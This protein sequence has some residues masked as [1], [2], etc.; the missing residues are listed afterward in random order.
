MFKIIQ[1][2]FKF[3]YFLFLIIISILFLLCEGVIH[4]HYSI[5]SYY[6]YS[7]FIYDRAGY[8]PLIW[9]ENGI[10]EF[11]QVFIL[12][13]S[14]IILFRYV[15]L[16]FKNLS[17]FFQ[18]ILSIYLIGLI[19]YF[20]E[21][22][23]YGQHFFFWLTPEFF[24]KL[25]SQNE[26]NLHNIN[27]LFNQLPRTLLLLFCSLSFLF[28]K[29][30]RFKSKNLA[31]FVLPSSKLK[32]LSCLILLFVIPDLIRDIFDIKPFFLSWEVDIYPFYV[33]VD[34]TQLLSF[35]FIRLSELQELL[36]NL[37]IISHVYYLKNFFYFW[38][39]Y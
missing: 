29:L 11:T 23:S 30:I 25:N 18:I 28:E 20:F 16:H 19:Y 15:K 4:N 33:S 37:Y 7:E 12:L 10:V 2:K 39:Y 34:L 35:T 5:F 8:N 38:D 32:Y 27:N 26:T 24:S 31:L 22:I 21:E 17:K 6:L 3:N 14:I 36:F 1:Q 9:E 13:L